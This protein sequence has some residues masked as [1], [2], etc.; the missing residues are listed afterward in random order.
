MS[1]KKIILIT[2]VII[3]ASAGVAY[4]FSKRKTKK[5]TGTVD[6]GESSATSDSGD[7][8]KQGSNDIQHVTQ[9]QE[10]LN[11]IHKAA[12]YINNTCSSIKWPLLS[13]GNAN[14][15]NEN[16]VFDSNTERVTKY[17]LARTEVDLDFLNMLRSKIDKYRKG[18]KCIYPL[19]IV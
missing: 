7:I 11:A 9:L 17:Y 10:V 13:G 6:V 16:G 1:T 14:V 2:L 12:W 15:V 19:S 4:A 5:D 18:D 8:L 3:M